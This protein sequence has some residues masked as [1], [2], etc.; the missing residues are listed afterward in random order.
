M[1]RKDLK[2][3]RDKGITADFLLETMHVR[4]QWRTISK[5][6]K[7]EKTVNLKSLPSEN[8]FQNEGKIKSFRHKS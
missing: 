7:G 1:K 2:G 8:I 6:V 4:R 5:T 3:V